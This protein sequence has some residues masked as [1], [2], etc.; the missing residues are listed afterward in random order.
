MITLIQMEYAVAVDTYR[1]FATAAEKCFVTQPTLSMQLKK[2]ESELGIDLFDRTKQP[3]VPT[4]AGERII[5]QARIVLQEA[6]KLQRIAGEL[7]EELSGNL[8]LGIIPTIAP[9]LLPRFAGSFKAR[10]P[11]VNLSI[12]EAV[13]GQIEEMLSKDLLDAGIVVTPLYRPDI[14]EEPLYYEGMLVYVH[15]GH[16]LYLFKELDAAS[17]NRPDIWLL[18]DG[19]CFRHQVVNLC[20]PV[21]QTGSP[22]PYS[23]EGGSLET[24]IRVIEREGG[25][26]I[27]PE[28]AGIELPADKQKN[29]RN[30]KGITPVREVSLVF[31]RKYVKSRLLN[32]LKEEIQ[33]NVPEEMLYP[34]RGTLVEWRS[35]N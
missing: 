29:L 20:H 12:Q 25:F 23:L 30:F 2:M 33:N 3:V 27:V 31:T 19:H 4:E 24:L 15:P 6:S 13:T 16:P 14:I 9:Y 5:A 18:N 22:L 21:S 1:H 10:F 28:L 35:P 8:R 26:T 7:H 34:E 17:L 32:M 11:A